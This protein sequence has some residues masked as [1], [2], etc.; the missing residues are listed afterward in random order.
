MTKGCPECGSHD[1]RVCVPVTFAF[2]GEEL[3]EQIST[4]LEI[5][6]DAEVSCQDCD[7][8]GKLCDLADRSRQ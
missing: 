7:W 4:E 5:P 1:L 3:G 2:D 6:K 8:W